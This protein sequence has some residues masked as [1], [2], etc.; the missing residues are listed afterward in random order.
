MMTGKIIR[1]VGGFYYIH[2]E[3]AEKDMLVEC[4]AKGIFRNRN[5]KPLVGDNVEFEMLDEEKKLG[6]I[7]EILPRKNALIRPAS[8]N[9]DQA[10]VVFA[11]SFPKPNLN[12]L[13]RFLVLMEKQNLPALI[14]MNKTDL[15]SD[16]MIA[17]VRKRYRNSGYPLLFV[18]AAQKEGIEAI[19]EYL[20]GK[21]TTVAGPSGVGKSSLINLLQDGVQMQTGAVSEKIERG[22][23]TTRHT[24]LMWVEEDTYIL[25]TPGFSSIE[26]FG[27]E[28]E[29]LGG[30]FPEIAAHA[31]N[32][33]FRG[34]AH[35]AEPDC[36]VK[37]AVDNGEISK[38]R[39]ENYQLLYEDLK[40]KT[41]Y[42]R[43][44]DT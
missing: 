8:A 42:G 6:N 41:G 10:V 25:D 7:Q 13:D 39:Y 33:R 2:P 28:K 26:L 15:A 18:S 27:I 30:Y 19:R 32:C 12:L 44:R 22:R 4:K 1:G 35:L 14:C 36:A 29:E 40:K 9:V 11:L 17:E 21:T 16:E 5:V 43:R 24:E 37:E 38:G 34:C 3:S 31:G 20:R 23:H